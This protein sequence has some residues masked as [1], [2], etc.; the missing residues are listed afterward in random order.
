LILS[1]QL[2][3]LLGSTVTAGVRV[4]GCSCLLVCIMYF[5]A[6][7]ITLLYS[8]FKQDHFAAGEAQNCG[9]T[10]PDNTGL[11]GGLCM[12]GCACD[13]TASCRKQAYLPV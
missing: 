2:Q 10:L 11:V 4:R 1:L 8:L 9:F 13:F 7:P 6:G 3:K 5:A 12:A